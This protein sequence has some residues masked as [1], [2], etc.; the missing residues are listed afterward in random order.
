MIIF[1]KD[2]SSCLHCS[3]ECDGFEI[4]SRF[5]WEH[6][7]HVEWKKEKHIFNRKI[8]TI[9]WK[10]W[11]RFNIITIIFF[12]LFLS[13]LYANMFFISFVNNLLLS[14]KNKK[15]YRNITKWDG[16]YYREFS[17]KIKKKQKKKL[18]N[19]NKFI[20]VEFCIIGSFLSVNTR[21]EWMVKCK[22]CLVPQQLFFRRFF[23]LYTTLCFWGVCSVCQSVCCSLFYIPLCAHV[24]P[25]SYSSF[26][27]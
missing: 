16:K 14:S 2:P 24:M 23:F 25:K 19:N 7:N 5:L 8:R 1:L 10:C 20:F 12:C 9:K 17:F 6:G 18:E 21:I 3:I 15:K 22:E 13:F 27:F 4:H 11:T 26:I